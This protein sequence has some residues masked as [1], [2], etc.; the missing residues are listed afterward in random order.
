MDNTQIKAD[1]EAYRALKKSTSPVDT[2]SSTTPSNL[3]TRDIK[4]DL[5]QYRASKITTPTPKTQEKT[6][7][8]KVGGVLN[9]IFGGGK[10]GEL[11][12]TQIA[13]SKAT[14]EEKKYITGPKASEVVGDIGNVALNF[15]PV[16]KIAKGLKVGGTALKL[17]KIA[18]PLSKIATGAGMGYGVDVVKN[19][20]EGKEQPFKPGAGTG[21]GAGIS[22]LPIVGKPVSKLLGSATKGIGSAL[23]GVSEDT[24]G[25]INKNSKVAKDTVKTIKKLGQEQ[26]LKNNVNDYVTGMTKFKKTASVKFGKALESLSKTDID[27]NLIK[28]SG[29]EALTNNGVKIKNGILDLTDSEILNPILQK[30]A[31]NIINTVNKT[32]FLDGKTIRESIKRIETS[33]IKNPGIDPDRLAFNKLLDNLISGFTSAISKATPKLAK[34][35]LAYSQSK[36]LADATQNILGKLKFKT[37]PEKLAVSKKIEGILTEPGISKSVLTDFFKSVGQDY[38]KFKTKEAVRQIS[39]KT[40]EKNSIGTNPFEIVRVLTSKIVTPKVVRDLA[41]LTGQTENYI[42]NLHL[43]NL[44]IGKRAILIRSLISQ[45]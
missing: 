11:I 37:L 18:E 26:I 7:M 32:P 39:N 34:A 29:L 42:K 17:G 9:S 22:A 10:I 13:K 5:A 4:T 41:I 2:I 36:G 1:L 19:L 14:E 40:L 23:S 38:E 33:K 3:T 44:S 6:G 12:G 43:E 15:A 20:S 21:I 30:R 31:L 8:E 45:E 25:L 28:N 24:I 16:G 35:N 27:E